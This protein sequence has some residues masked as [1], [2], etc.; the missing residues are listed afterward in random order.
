MKVMVDP[1]SNSTFSMVRD[2]TDEMVLHTMMLNG[3]SLFLLG[4]VDAMSWGLSLASTSA[5][6][7]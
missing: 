7:R 6:R 3:V 5:Y 2:R 1:G 4:M